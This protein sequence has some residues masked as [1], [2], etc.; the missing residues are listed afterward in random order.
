[1]NKIRLV[2]L[3]LFI[4]CGMYA[5]TSSSSSR[6]NTLSSK[7]KQE[8]WKLLFDGTTKNGWH[9]FNNRTDGAAWKVEQGI[10]YL[11]PK[12]K[13]P[14]GEGGGDIIT[15]D[16]FENFHLK[17]EWK[18]DSGGNSGVVIQAIEDPKY[19]WPWLTG[20]EIQIVDNNANPD[21]KIKKHRTS[22]LY[23]LIS[24]SPETSKRAGEWNQME[25][26]QNNGKLEVLLNG[27][28]VLSATQWDDNWSKL[29][30]ESKFKSMA[31]FGKYRKGKIALQDHG[32]RVWFRNVMIK[33]L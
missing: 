32:D 31:D 20:P 24:A 29:V 2:I 23:D 18:I 10:L 4:T 22:D 8:G 5:Q 19:R 28:K 6:P 12:A 13:G 1:M 17:L 9:V 26:M 15:V 33:S 16:S 27:T 7:E 14:N 11:D 21:A 30:S 3:S 25:V